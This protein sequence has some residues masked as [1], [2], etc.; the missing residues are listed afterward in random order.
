MSQKVVKHEGDSDTSFIWSPWNNLN[1][2]EKK[3]EELKIR[4]R[5]ETVQ[6]TTLLKLARIL[7]RVLES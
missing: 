6:T 3:L 1:N 4:G 5:I 7:R 2:M